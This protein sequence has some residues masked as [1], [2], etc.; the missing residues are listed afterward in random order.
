VSRA[1][2][3]EP[4][5]GSWIVS[6]INGRKVFETFRMDTAERAKAA[7]WVVE[8]AAQYLARINRAIYRE[9]LT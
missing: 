5:C 9:V 8:T 7:G 1:P 2:E 6:S 3:L 4:H